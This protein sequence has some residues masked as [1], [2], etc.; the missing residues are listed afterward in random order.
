MASAEPKRLCDGAKQPTWL[1]RRRSVGRAVS[2]GTLYGDVFWS[3]QTFRIFE[4]DTSTKPSID[5]MLQR[6]HPDDV[7]AVRRAF[8]RAKQEG[9][10]F[11]TEFH[12]LMPRGVIKHIHAVAHATANGNGKR[13]FVGAFMDV[14]AAGTAEQK[15]NETR[16]SSHTLDA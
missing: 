14:T 16:E 1:K 2:G 7:A 6:V 12:L 10:D 13:Q 11:D 3:E 5:L 9:M 4:Y 8:D 15:L